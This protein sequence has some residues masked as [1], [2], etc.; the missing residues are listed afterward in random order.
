[1]RKNRERVLDLLA[2]A[3]EFTQ[4]CEITL[5]AG[6]LAPAVEHLNTAAELAVMTLIQLEGWNDNRQH[7][8]RQEWLRQASRYS[9]VPAEFADAYD[10]LAAERNPA[11]YA[12]GPQALTPDQL[13][14]LRHAVNRLINYASARRG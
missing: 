1:M 14:E 6:L 4:A 8:K 5:Q 3:N 2:R 7:R 9:D 13:D 11:R 10:R 12:E